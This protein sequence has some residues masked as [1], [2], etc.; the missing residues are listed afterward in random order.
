MSMT[1][2]KRGAAADE[3]YQLAI[4]SPAGGKEKA[5]PLRLSS[6]S[7][8]SHF[9]KSLRGRRD[10]RWHHLRQVHRTRAAPRPLRQVATHAHMYLSRHLP[11]AV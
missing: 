2:K 1:S 9:T 7:V 6:C 5:E 3:V 4:G 8:M 11:S 10:P